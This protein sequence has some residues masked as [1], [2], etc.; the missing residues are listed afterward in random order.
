[1]IQHPHPNIPSTSQ[2]FLQPVDP[3]D[4]NLSIVNTIADSQSLSRNID[5][6]STASSVTSVGP[7]LPHQTRPVSDTGSFQPPPAPFYP[8]YNINTSTRI[9][10]TYP[11]SAP[12]HH[13]RHPYQGSQ[14]SGYTYPPYVVPP[15]LTPFIIPTSIPPHGI[16]IESNSP[17]PTPQSPTPLANTINDLQ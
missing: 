9:N 5:N 2:E 16:P 10:S 6:V 1:M 17:F 8:Q 11:A 3:N 15:D 4:T 12:I 14:R 13:L 7:H